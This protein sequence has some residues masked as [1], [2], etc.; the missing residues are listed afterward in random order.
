MRG[1]RSLVPFTNAIFFDPPDSRRVADSTGRG[2]VW[3]FDGIS[4]QRGFINEVNFAAVSLCVAVGY[5]GH[6]RAPHVERNVVR[7]NIV[8]QNDDIAIGN[9][10][11]SFHK[12]GWG[13][14]W[15]FLVMT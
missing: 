5:R 15:G 1:C 14:S 13:F 4:F 10:L 12:F 11:L 8:L 7:N 3:K 2:F 6:S 9:W